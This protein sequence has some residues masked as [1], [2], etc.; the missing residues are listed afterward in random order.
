VLNIAE[1]GAAERLLLLVVLAVVAA[2]LAYAAEARLR[3]WWTGAHTVLDCPVC[4][5]RRA[6]RLRQGDT[7]ACAVCGTV[8]LLP[9]RGG[10]A[11]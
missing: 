7:I 6:H 8:R 10:G 5:G 1:L 4:C 11:R 2:T 9:H 3:T